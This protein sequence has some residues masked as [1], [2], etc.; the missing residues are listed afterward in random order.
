MIAVVYE[1]QVMTGEVTICYHYRFEIWK[2]YCN[3]VT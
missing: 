2:K 1:N 3:F